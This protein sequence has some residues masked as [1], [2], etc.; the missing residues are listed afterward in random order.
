MSS[1]ILWFVG[2]LAAGAVLVMMVKAPKLEGCCLDLANAARD[3]I[4]E[5]VGGGRGGVAKALDALGF[6]KY[7]PNI[8]GAMR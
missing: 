3:K 8:I 6:T 7:L 5:T 1:S 4:D 2:G